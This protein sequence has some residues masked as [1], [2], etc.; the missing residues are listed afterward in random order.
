MREQ[1]EK[2]LELNWEGLHVPVHILS[3][4]GQPSRDLSAEVFHDNPH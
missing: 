4:V 1:V 2:G 3:H